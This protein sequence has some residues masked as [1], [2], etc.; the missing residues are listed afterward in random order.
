MFVSL[1][2]HLS[3]PVSGAR[4]CPHGPEMVT[5]ETGLQA[6]WYNQPAPHGSPEKPGCLEIKSKGAF[7]LGT[8]AVLCG[9]L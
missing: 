2:C 9:K 6:S 3:F 4:R 7:G 5:L 8:G 1:L